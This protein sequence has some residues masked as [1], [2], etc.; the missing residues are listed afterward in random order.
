[1]T[2]PDDNAYQKWEQL[3]DTVY[4]AA[5]STLGYKKRHSQDWFDETDGAISSLLEHKGTALV[6]TLEH[7]SFSV[8]QA[9]K[10][11]CRIVQA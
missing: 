9:H 11:V 4:A 3:R 8:V 1:M 10:E 7:P 5:A 6:R 2:K